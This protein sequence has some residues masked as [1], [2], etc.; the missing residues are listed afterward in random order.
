MSMMKELG[1]VDSLQYDYAGSLALFWYNMVSN[2]LTT[3]P[4]GALLM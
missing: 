4:G 1:L 2:R 3:G